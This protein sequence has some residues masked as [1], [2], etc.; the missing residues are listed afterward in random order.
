MNQPD[1]LSTIVQYLSGK[2]SCATSPMPDLSQSGTRTRPRLSIRIL[3]PKKVLL[4][5]PAMTPSGSSSSLVR[6]LSVSGGSNGSTTSSALP[7]AK[8]S[9]AEEGCSFAT[10]LKLA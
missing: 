3:F 4:T 6:A 9:F 10:A 5:R 7:I 2:K 8:R 1:R